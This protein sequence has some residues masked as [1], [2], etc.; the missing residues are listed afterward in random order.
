[1]K[2]GIKENHKIKKTKKSRA[3]I[4]I[5]SIL[6]AIFIPLMILYL[7]VAGFYQNHFYKNTVI[8]GIDTSNMTLNEAEDL[9]NAKVKSYALTLKERN[10]ITDTITGDSIQL[11][12]VFEKNI[13][14]LLVEQKSY[15]WPVTLF[16]PH[17]ID[18][19]SMLE[20]DDSLL[21]KN[22]KNLNC[23]KKENDIEP[24][25][26]SISEYGENGYEIIPE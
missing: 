24:V 20:Y 13:S 4:W 3:R 26:A 21:Q 5:L 14:D 15:R 7:Y 23:F 25:N 22:F 18:V 9:I 6:A 8:N 16:K 17:E 2:T 1:M 10:D 11:H 12:S 19:K